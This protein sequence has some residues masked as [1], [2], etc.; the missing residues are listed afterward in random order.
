MVENFDESLRRYTNI[1]SRFF[2]K[3]TLNPVHHNK[4][5]VSDLAMIDGLALLEESLDPHI[6][7]RFVEHNQRDYDLY[8]WASATFHT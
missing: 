6:V 2:P 8:R 5:E 1:Y 7:R 4:S 3:L